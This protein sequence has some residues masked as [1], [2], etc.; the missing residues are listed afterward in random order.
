MRARAEKYEHMQ[1]ALRSAVGAADDR[2]LTSDTGYDTS[3]TMDATG[4]AEPGL[5]R[6]SR[7]NMEPANLRH[8][9]AR[10]LKAHKT[11]VS[12]FAKKLGYPRTTVQSWYKGKGSEDA[13]PIPKAA[14]QAIQAEL[15]VP[16]TAW[17]RVV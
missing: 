14:A 11:T 12:A 9:F 6:R 10:A 16:L 13:R 7:S 3:D 15:G 8:P 5:V 4:I 1:A 17:R 2:V